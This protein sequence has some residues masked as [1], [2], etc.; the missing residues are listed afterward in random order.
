[1]LCGTTPNSKSGRWDINFVLTH[2]RTRQRSEVL[3]FTCYKF[4]L[5]RGVLSENIYFLAIR[6]EESGEFGMIKK[7]GHDYFINHC[8]TNFL[9][10]LP[11]V[12]IIRKT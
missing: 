1:M 2:F 6:D 5:K 11:L 3:H 12:L 7:W 8:F 10:I 9:S 4:A